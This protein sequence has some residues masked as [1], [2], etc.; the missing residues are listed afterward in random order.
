M[1]L[2][3][4]DG[5]GTVFQRDVAVCLISWKKSISLKEKQNILMLLSGILNNADSCGN[6]ESKSRKSHKII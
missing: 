3:F 1:L 6:V 4:D 5:M 2:T